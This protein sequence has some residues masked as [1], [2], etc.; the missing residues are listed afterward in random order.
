MHIVIVG[1]GAIGTLLAAL[2]QPQGHRVSL[3]VRRARTAA[4]IRSRGMVVLRDT[5]R[6]QLPAPAVATDIAELAP[7]D[8]VCMCVKAYDTRAAAQAVRPAVQAGTLVLTL[9][10]GLGNSEILQA[11]LPGAQVLAGTTS[12]GATLHSPGVVRH[13]GP[14][15][16]VIGACVP[17]HAMRAAEV[18]T[19]FRHAGLHCTTAADVAAIVWSKVVVNCAIN[20]LGAL[21]AVPN[22]RLLELPGARQLLA[23]TASE[24]AA[25][26]RACGVALLYGDPAAKAEQVCRATAANRCS[27][28]QDL[29]AGRRTEIDSINGAVARRASDLG[30][31]AGCNAMLAG[32]VRSAGDLGLHAAGR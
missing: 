23:E 3:L 25:V 16:T 22:G 28:L 26:A 15:E 17:A 30:L 1:A 14:G 9:Q 29:E 32:L 19:L 10:N 8:L 6:L 18:C 13:S 4:E 24:A 7:A 11:E 20:P 12:E 5:V 31:A 2:L 21:L 27:M